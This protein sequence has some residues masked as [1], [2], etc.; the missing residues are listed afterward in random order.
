MDEFRNLKKHEVLLTLK[1]DLAMAVQVS[2]IVEEW[3]DHALYK[4]KENESRCIVATK[5]Q[6]KAKKKYKES[7]FRLAKRRRSWPLPKKKIELQRKELEGREAE[8]S[9][10]EQAAY[11]LG[12]KETS[13]SLTLQIRDL[14]HGFYLKVWIEA[15]NATGVDSSSDLKDPSKIIYPSTLRGKASSSTSA[16]GPAELASQPPPKKEGNDEG[17]LGKGDKAREQ[18]KKNSTR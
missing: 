8:L 18:K 9:K 7:F 4:F 6:A 1:R 14:G 3:V 17:P 15:L 13:A 5:A 16:S 10:A 12:Q 11:K 2:C